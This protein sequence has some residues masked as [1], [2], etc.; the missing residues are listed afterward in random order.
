MKTS[1]DTHRDDAGDDGEAF[2]PGSVRW[3]G[4]ADTPRGPILDGADPRRWSEQRSAS[5]GERGQATVEFAG[6]LMLIVVLVLLIGQVLVVA[7]ARVAV[8]N[9]AR[10]GV[11]ELSI[12]ATDAQVAAAIRDIDQRANLTAAQRAQPGQTSRIRVELRIA[13]DVPI[14]GVLVPDVTVSAS[15]TA[16]TE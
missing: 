9:A 7:Q 11:R 6:V 8:E 14:V 16:R 2:S 12:G 1:T 15:A 10:A 5:F 13:T 4:R 3:L